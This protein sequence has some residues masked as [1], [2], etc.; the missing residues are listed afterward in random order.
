[1]TNSKP[2]WER[3]RLHEMSDEEW[4]SLCDGCARC[5]LRKLEDAD[6]GE[7]YYTDV[8]CRLLDLRRCR[9]RHYGARL[10]LVADCVDLRRAPPDAFRWMPSTCAYRK[11]AEGKPLEWWHPLVSGDPETVHLAGVSV[12]GRAISERHVHERDVDERVVDWPK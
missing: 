2:F 8:A 1:M 5:C 3:K 11:I 12:R 6:T 7:I 9:C 10:R 4:E